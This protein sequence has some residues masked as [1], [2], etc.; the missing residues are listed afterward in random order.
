[1][2]FPLRVILALAVIGAVAIIGG[3][4]IVT[5]LRAKSMS[6]SQR[7]MAVSGIVIVVAAL[8]AW[9]IFVWPAYWD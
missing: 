3:W 9:V 4:A 7:T 2:N 6:Q 5:V 1:M 8:L